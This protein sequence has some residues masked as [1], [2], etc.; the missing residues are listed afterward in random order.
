[1]GMSALP[2]APGLECVRD[3]PS[4]EP[5]ERVNLP[6]ADTDIDGLF[7]EDFDDA[8]DSAY[9]E[10]DVH[11]Q[12]LRRLRD[13]IAQREEQLDALRAQLDV[14]TEALDCA[15]QRAAAALAVQHLLFARL[16]RP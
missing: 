8:F 12:E 16:L 11:E 1:M 5:T 3:D 9:E 6:R 13:V 4:A 10:T 14:L 7:D 15:D 2:L